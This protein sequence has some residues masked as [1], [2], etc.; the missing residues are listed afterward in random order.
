MQSTLRTRRR[1]FPAASLAAV[2]LA[3]ALWPSGALAFKQGYHEQVTESVLRGQ[4]FDEDSAD[5]V[6]D[7]NYYTDVF[8]PNN[9]SAH[10]DGNQLGAAS[11]RLRAKRTA[12][13]DALNA[14]KRRDALDALGEALHTVQDIYSHS[15]AVENGH[16][17]DLLNLVN[18]SAPCNPATN[19]APGGLVTGHFS[20]GGFLLTWPD[21]SGQCF[22]KPANMCCHLQLNK[23]SPDEPNGARHGTAL[24]RARAATTEYMGLLESDIRSRFPD[25]ADQLV[26][27]LK[28]KQRTAIFVIDDT[29]SMSNDIAGV[30]A[31]ANAF[32]DSVVAANESPTLGLVTFKDGATHRG[33]SCNNI[34][35]LRAQINGLFASGGGDCPEA[36]NAGLLT[37]LAQVPSGRADIQIQ[38]GRLLLATDASARDPQLGPTVADQ[39]F[40][41]GV[42]IDAILTGDCVAEEG[43]TLAP[44]GAPA[45]ETFSENEPGAAP[46]PAPET[47]LLAFNPLTSRSARTYLRALTEQTG[48]VLFN[49]S[50]LEVDDVAPT[51]LAL[52]DPDT[53]IVFTRRLQGAPGA[54]I[55]VDIPVDETFTGEVTFMLTASTPGG[56]PAF[57]L[58]RPDGSLVQPGDPG[59][60]RRVLSSVVSYAVQAPAVGLWR[61]TLTG[62]AGAVLRAFGAT[63]LRFNGLRYLVPEQ[64]PSR[65]EAEL[66]SLDGLPVAGAELVA[67]ARLSESPTNGSLH[68]R[69]PDGTL[70]AAPTTVER[71]GRRFQAPVTIPGEIFQVELSGV[72]AGGNAYVRQLP[73][74]VVPR[75]VALRA[76]PNLAVAAPGTSATFQIEVRNASADPATYTLSATSTLAWPR[77]LPAPFAVAPGAT[78]TVNV[79]VSVPAGTPPDTRNDL[80]LVVQDATSPPARN[81]TSVAVVAGSPNQPPD[82]GAASASTPLLWPPNHGFAPVSVLGVTDPDNDVVTVTVTGITQDEAVDAP[83]SGN[84]APDG[85]GVGGSEAAV[86]AERAGGGDGR[87]YAITFSAADGRGGTC[88]G[89]VSVGVPHSQNGAAPVDSGQSFDSTVVP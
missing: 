20:L 54:S 38:G 16:A 35:T 42:S 83:G 40:L 5:E 37:G 36:M 43:L 21:P 64:T 26:N 72:T 24:A 12:V 9:A 14:C 51:L 6:G 15:N 32:L 29:G 84:T 41:R 82:C 62:G 59:V 74:A 52:S 70:L 61:A 2:A 73:V 30:K 55:V 69:R 44:E 18:G 8:E 3:S 53:A 87:V 33:T 48:G 63:T 76:N 66:A 71:D 34:S 47:T 75:T 39:A 13:G 1:L 60:T 45:P 58:R 11:Q 27:L 19:F 7:S 22:F 17:V 10:A 67:D 56:L 49:V 25:K 57:E 65:P 79:Q 77:V 78:V 4:G 80:T 46:E 31:A 86:R 23:D 81:T 88:S 89:S 68:L 28:R 50:R 85:S